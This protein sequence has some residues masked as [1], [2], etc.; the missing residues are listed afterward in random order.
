MFIITA[1]FMD[2]PSMTGAQN[3]TVSMLPLQ[4]DKGALWHPDSSGA[5]FAEQIGQI[6]QPVRSGREEAMRALIMS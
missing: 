3:V 1:R 4:A 2:T 6:E 5:A